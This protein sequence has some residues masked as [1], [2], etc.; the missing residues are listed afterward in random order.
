[1]LSKVTCNLLAG[2][3]F[4]GTLPPK[5]IFTE[6]FKLLSKESNSKTF[7][8]AFNLTFTKNFHKQ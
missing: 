4:I 8:G 1:M 3:E 6:G 5:A 7:T 2:G